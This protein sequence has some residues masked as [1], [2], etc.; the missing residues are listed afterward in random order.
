[1]GRK[2]AEATKAC[3]MRRT[4]GEI[5]R[6]FRVVAGWGL[7]ALFPGFLT[8]SVWLAGALLGCAVLRLL[9]APGAG[10]FGGDESV[11]VGA[12]LA[13]DC[14]NAASSEGRTKKP[15]KITAAS[16]DHFEPICTALIF[17]GDTL[18]PESCRNSS[19][20]NLNP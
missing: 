9:A 15:Q 8:G 5:G 19:G 17:R 7:T 1:M 6:R 16:S 13:A 14:C 18:L 20:G 11:W 4:R 3:R 10:G 2:L 12:E